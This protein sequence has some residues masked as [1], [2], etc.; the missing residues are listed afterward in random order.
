MNDIAHALSP[1]KVVVWGEAAMGYLGA[2]IL[3]NVSI[4]N[5]LNSNVY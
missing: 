1:I 4:I 3:I 5:F 2:G